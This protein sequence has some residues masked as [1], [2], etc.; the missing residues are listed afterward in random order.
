M[1]EQYVQWWIRIP[2]AS[3]AAMIAGN[4]SA[5]ERVAAELHRRRR[6]GKR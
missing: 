5:L 4:R 6:P 3:R 1:P 2:R